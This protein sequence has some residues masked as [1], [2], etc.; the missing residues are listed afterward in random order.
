MA[1]FADPYGGTWLQPRPGDVAALVDAPREARGRRAGGAAAGRTGRRRHRAPRS[2]REAKDAGKRVSIIYAPNP[3]DAVAAGNGAR[4]VANLAIALRGEK[5]AEALTV[6]PTEANVYGARD[7]GVDPELAPGRTALAEPGMSFDEMIDAASERRAEGA[8]RRRRQPANVRARHTRASVQRS[9]RSTFLVVIDSLMTDT[10]KAAHVVLADVPS[11]GK[12]GTYTNGERRVNRMHAALAALGDARPALLALSDLANAIGG[13]DTWTYA[14]PDAVTDEIAATVPGY[15]RFRADFAMWGKARAAGTA[16]RA[17]RQP[18][19]AAA[20]Q[21]SGGRTAA[22]DG[23]HTV[24]EPRRRRARTRPTPTSCT[25]RSS[26]N[27]T[28]PTPRRCGSPT[29]RK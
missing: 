2:S 14:H 28:R 17:E 29:K 23:P 20:A 10:A 13:A 6:L 16:S 27:C 15:E 26:S 4:A 18:V 19:A 25:A 9:K 11:Y 22:D 12:T 3:G 7:M 21:A 5:A 1:D 24:H 8:R